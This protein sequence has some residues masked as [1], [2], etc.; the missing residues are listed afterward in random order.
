MHASRTRRGGPVAL[1]LP[2]ASP[3]PV[4]PALLVAAALLLAAA[5]QAGAACSMNVSGAKCVDSVGLNST[6]K[7]SHFTKVEQKP[8]PVEIGEALPYDY[9]LLLNSEYFGL[10]PAQDGW[11]YFRV[12]GRVLRADFDTRE[13]IE[14][15]THMTNRAFF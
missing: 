12:E 5:T 4:G 6:E 3:A 10:P 2:H 9:M 11:A 14:D 1:T 7:S 8:L 15:V 13:V